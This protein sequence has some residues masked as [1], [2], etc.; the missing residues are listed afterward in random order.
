MDDYDFPNLHNLWDDYIKK[1]ELK[2]LDIY[3]YNSRHHDIKYI[4][5]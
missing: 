5:N 1:Y 3:L 2:P 4:R